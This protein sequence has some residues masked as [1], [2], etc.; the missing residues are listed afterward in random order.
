MT[1]KLDLVIA[2]RTLAEHGVIDAYGHA[3]ARSEANPQRYLMARNLAP[4]LV[5]EADILEYDLESNPINAGGIAV[6]NERF[7]HGE[8]YKLRPDVKAIVHNHSHAVIPFSC[9]GVALQP[10]FHMSAFIGL[11]VP[12]WDIR[13]ARKGSDLL[14]RDA[15]LGEHLARTLGKHPAVLMRGH[16]STV[17]GE[18]IQ[19][20]VGR[21]IYLDINAR[22]QMQAIALANGERPIV[23]MDEAEVAANVSWQNY[24]RAWD[25]WKR[26]V[27]E[28][29]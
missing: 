11:G 19:R 17:V 20:A 18:N 6:Y 22:M 1:Q 8:I 13:D 29:L 16:G 24:D 23:F 14:V 3:S 27:V 2:S 28:R 12:G 26:K 7:I 21:S 15:F 25:L 9:T 5:T 10:I 4:E